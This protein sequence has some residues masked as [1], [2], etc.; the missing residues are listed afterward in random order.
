VTGDLRANFIHNYFDIGWWGLY[1]GGTA[2]FLNIYATRCGATPSQIGL[3]SAGP[4]LLT[5]LLS[6]PAGRLV[7]RYSALRITAVTSLLVRSLFLL[8]ALLP[9]IAPKHQVEAILALV[10]VVTI[11]N[12]ALGISFPKLFMEALPSEW[13]GSVVGTRNAIYALVCFVT[14]LAA[15]QILTV[16]P[17]PTGYQIVFAIG[18]VGAIMT[19]FNLRQVRPLVAEDPKDFPKASRIGEAANDASSERRV[20]AG[21]RLRKLLKERPALDG[22]GRKYV[23]VI[24]LLFFFN[25]VANMAAPV[26]P[27]MMVNNLHLSDALISWGTASNSL[28]F[29]GVSLFIAQAMRRLGNRWG[30]GVS[31][32][33]LG[34]QL[35]IL[36]FAR[37]PLMYF[38]SVIVGGIGTGIQST[39][40]YNYHLDHVP[41]KNR[42]TWLSLNQILGNSAVLLG[43]VVGPLLAEQIGTPI[44]LVVFAVMRLVLGAVILRWG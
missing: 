4:A 33:F 31:T 42:A 10:M 30:A 5:L 6:L 21:E 34:V 26:I 24:V 12:A 18:F 3:L 8:Y 20:G 11:P 41:Q 37:G 1:A 13:R 39:A 28:L 44:S 36:A 7:S 38:V 35:A 17:F 16:F 23:R 27:G 14:T 2:A 25:V 43:A 22:P 15:G 9:W 19:A 32:L 40:Q 29:F